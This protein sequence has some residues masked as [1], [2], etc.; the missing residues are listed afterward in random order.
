MG[1]P[2]CDVLVPMVGL[3]PRTEGMGEPSCEVLV[4]TE[5]LRSG[6]KGWASPV[7]MFQCP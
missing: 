2:R 6:M 1:A 7:V 5:E 4:P 3:R